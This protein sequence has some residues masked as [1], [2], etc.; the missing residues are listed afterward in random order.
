MEI[1]H[2]S[3]ND[4]IHVI[5]QT[6]VAGFIFIAWWVTHFASLVCF[7]LEVREMMPY[8][9][10]SACPSLPEHLH[11]WHLSAVTSGFILLLYALLRTGSFEVWYIYFDYFCQTMTS[12]RENKKGNIFVFHLE[13]TLRCLLATF[14]LK[15]SRFKCVQEPLG[16]NLSYYYWL[17]LSKIWLRQTPMWF[18][19]LP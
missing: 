2:F 13:R 3:D 15:S 11:S 14:S 5:D 18:E 16:L 7:Y 19:F 4:R 12:L 17:T 6:C 8:I 9:I 1:L 10:T